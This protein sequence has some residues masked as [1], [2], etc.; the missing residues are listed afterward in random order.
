MTRHSDR[1][2]IEVARLPRSTRLAP[3]FV[4]LI[5]DSYAERTAS[6]FGSAISTREAAGPYSGR[7]SRRSSDLLTSTA[8]HWVC[9]AKWLT[10]KSR[11]DRHDASISAGPELPGDPIMSR[12]AGSALR[13]TGGNR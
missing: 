8:C 5:G 1:G 11:D 7:M 12:C 2:V 4:D 3:G 6:R 10:A 9:W 13:S